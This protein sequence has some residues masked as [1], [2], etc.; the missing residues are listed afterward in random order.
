MNQ[1]TK[2]T[3]TSAQYFSD[4]ILSWF[5]QQGRKHL[6]WQQNK[7]PYRVWISEI[8]LQQTQ[9]ATVIPYYQRFMAS[10]P[11]INDLA[12]ADEDNVLHHWTGLGYY[13]RARNLHK[14]AKIIRDQYQ[15]QFP[16]DIE[17]VV[18]LPGIGRS[19]AGAILSLSLKQHHAIL[20]GNVKRVLA[21]YYLVEGHNAQAKFEKALWPI[22]EQLTPKEEVENYNQA[23][24]DIGAMVCTRTK[25]L[26]EQCPVN[27]GCLAYAGNEQANFPQKKPKKTTPVKQTIMLIPRVE[28]QVLME[29]RPP[30]GIWGGLYCFLELADKNAINETLTDLGLTLEKTTQLTEFRHTFSHF[31]LDIEPILVDC[32][33]SANNLVNEPADFNWYKL[34]DI[35]TVGLAASSCKILDEIK[36]L[37]RL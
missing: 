21:R 31:H 14:A 13:A 25:P 27:D 7:T 4:N 28:N 1:S 34:D 19:T 2:I 32:A 26:C 8:M 16:Q 18:A 15:G 30:A 33:I 17:Q 3:N 37:V 29:K 11:T 20:D 24:M 12:N 6:P 9:V 23:M 35:N 10:F 36:Q 5:H 22:A